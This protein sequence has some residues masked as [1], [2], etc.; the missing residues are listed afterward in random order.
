M[1]LL[2]DASLVEPI[3]C[4]PCPLTTDWVQ[5]WEGTARDGWGERE[6]G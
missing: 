6:N 1:I 4:L 5:P 2:K 3:N